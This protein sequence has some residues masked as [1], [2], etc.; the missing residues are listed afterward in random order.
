MLICHYLGMR[1]VRQEE[2]VG[3]EREIGM[4]VIGSIVEQWRGHGDV[5]GFGGSVFVVPIIGNA[6]D[7]P[8]LSNEYWRKE[9]CEGILRVGIEE[10]VLSGTNH[11]HREG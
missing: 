2:I 9:G 6:R 3:R 5:D 1:G 7:N 11:T 8:R 4:S 10:D